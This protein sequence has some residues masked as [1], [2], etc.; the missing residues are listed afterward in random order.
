MKERKSARGDL[1]YFS[2]ERMLPE[3]FAAAQNLKIGETST[4]IRS[5]LGY[6]LL[7]L[8]EAL[9]AREMTLQEASPEIAA[10]LANAQR[11]ATLAQFR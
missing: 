10:K 7:R 3:V 2:A 5:R 8:T 9:P 6:H 4:P 11:A 1:G